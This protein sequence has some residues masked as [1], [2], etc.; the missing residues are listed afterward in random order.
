MNL[1]LEGLYESDRNDQGYFEFDAIASI[2]FTHNTDSKYL[3]LN[4]GNNP[5]Y[6][7]LNVDL[8]CNDVIQTQFEH[9]KEKELLII[10]LLV[11]KKKFQS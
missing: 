7:V 11:S 4:A 3:V 9:Y 2:L 10:Q 5:G 6:E 1:R 8:A